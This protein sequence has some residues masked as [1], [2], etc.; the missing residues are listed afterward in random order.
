MN[1]TKNPSPAAIASQ[2]STGQRFRCTSDALAKCF[3][4]PLVIQRAQSQK[5]RAGAEFFLDPQQLILLGD[6][7]GAG[8]G[9]RFD[10]AGAGGDCE[11]GD[12]RVFAFAGAV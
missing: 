6:A 9:T 2:A 4:L 7:I 3:Q 10:L 8:G 5:A 1:T 12:E 11:I